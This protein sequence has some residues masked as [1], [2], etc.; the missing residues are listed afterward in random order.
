MELVINTLVLGAIYSLLAAGIVVIYKA[1]RVVNFA[2]GEFAVLGAY[3]YFSLSQAMPGVPAILVVVLVTAICAALGATLYHVLMR[4][5][6]GRPPFVAAMVTIGLAIILKAAIVIGWESRSVGLN[7]TRIVLIDY[8]RGFRL[9]LIEA[10]TIVT[11]IAAFTGIF[12]FFRYASLGRQ[13]RGVAE[14]ALL[15]SQRQV[16]INLILALAWALALG[17]AVIAGVLFGG[18]SILTPQSVFIGLSGLT[19]ALVGGLD[20]FRGALFGGFLVAAATY[21]TARLVDPSLAEAV[22]FV[23]LLA[24]MLWRPWGVF[25]TR[26]E[27][28]RV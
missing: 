19:A 24:V 2:H 26:E 1:S 10:I 5:L 21:L 14:S 13:F 3:L 18:R 20:S 7:L 9:T 12:A 23:L 28:N 6:V 22:P 4:R 25:G 16:N 17:S 11:C 15:A 8:G 27:L